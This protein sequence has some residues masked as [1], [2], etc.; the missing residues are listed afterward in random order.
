MVASPS[1][2]ANAGRKYRVNG[3]TGD[4]LWEKDWRSVDLK[5]EMFVDV[6][7]LV[8]KG[9]EAEDKLHEDAMHKAKMLHIT[10][11]KRMDA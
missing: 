9:T 3:E 4:I 10:H 2:G 6:D 1:H 11:G 8:Q 7:E 5:S